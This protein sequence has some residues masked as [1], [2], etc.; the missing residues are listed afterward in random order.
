MNKCVML[1]VLVSMAFAL[2]LAST[3]CHSEAKVD[4]DGAKAEVRPK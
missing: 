4:E 2:A 1:M 3:G